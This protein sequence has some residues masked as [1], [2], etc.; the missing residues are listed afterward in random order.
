MTDPPSPEEL[1]RLSTIVHNLM[2]WAYLPL[3]LVLLME[4]LRGVSP[5]WR[6]YLWPALSAVFG[7]GLAIWI[8]YYQ[9][10]HH[11]PP[12]SDPLQNQHQAIGWVVAIGALVELVRRSGRLTPTIAAWAEAVW[13]ASLVGVGVIFLAHEQRSLGTLLAHLA[14]AGTLVLAGFAYLA[15]VLAR[16]GGRVA[17]VFGTLLLFAAAVQLVVYEEEV[18]AHG[19][20]PMLEQVGGH[21]GH[22]GGP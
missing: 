11:V 21:A 19:A 12:F 18:G 2:G 6:R 13:P 20:P 15:P 10:S 7:V 22:V 5:S 9:V 4:S 16:E 8:F 14:L 1:A 17:R 3:N